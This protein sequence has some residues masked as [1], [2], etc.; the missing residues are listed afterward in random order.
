MTEIAIEIREATPADAPG[1]ATLLRRAFGE[2]E[3]LYTAR[4]FAAT[5][6]GAEGLVARMEE[7]PVWIALRDGAPIAT[8]SVVPRGE[9]L[10]IR[11]MA[12]EPA[13]R[14]VGVGRAL[15]RAIESYAT[16]HGFERLF[17]STTPFLA[18]AIALYERAGF[19]RTDEGPGHLHGT[20][21]FTMEKSVG[22]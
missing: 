16:E 22:R 14:G 1:I 18:A 9:A 5:V 11:G 12:A 15:L 8:V 19:R 2:F 17:L 13:A 21:L 10:Y 4:A 3:P 20:P 6:P 7:G